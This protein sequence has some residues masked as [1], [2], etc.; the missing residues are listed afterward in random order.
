MSIASEISRIKQNIAS[1][2]AACREKAADL[3]QTQNSA[4]LASTIDSIAVGVPVESLSYSQINEQVT[5]FL[6]SVTYDPTDY[7]VSHIAEYVIDHDGHRPAGATITAPVPG[8]LTVYDGNGS[9]SNT[10]SAGSITVKNITPGNTGIYVLRDQNDEIAATGLLKPTGQLRMVDGGTTTFNIRDI[11]GWACDG[12]ALKHGLLFRGCELNGEN[13]VSINEEQRKLFVDFLG[14]R[15]EVDLRGDSETDGNDDIP[16][17]NDDI[18]SSALGPEVD[19]ARYPIIQ[20]G[21]TTD[22]QRELYKNAL[23]RMI[24]SI[25]AG[26][27]CY[28]HCMQG[29]DR[30]GT[31]IALIEGLCGVSQR[32][33][34]KD[35]ELT[36]LYGYS[37]CL[38]ERTNPD[39]VR[40]INAISAM[41][42]NLF[43]DKVVSYV[44][45]LGVSIQSINAL[46]NALINGSPAQ[47]TSPFSDAGVTKSLADISIDNP[48]AS[49]PMYQPYVLNMEPVGSRVISD[50][51]VT[52]G[53]VDITQSVFSGTKTLLRRNITKTLSDCSID[54]HKSVI[55]D[56]ECYAATITA[57]S[58]YTMNGATVNITMGGINVSNYYSDGK[59][60]IPRVTG[61][62]VIT[63]TAVS[64][65][66]PTNWIKESVTEIG[67]STIYNGVGYKSETRYKSGM[68]E[69]GSTG[70]FT[71]GYIKLEPGDVVRLYGGIFSATVG[72]GQT[73]P[74]NL[75]TAIY[76]ASGTKLLQFTIQTIV[77]DASAADSSI[78]LIKPLTYDPATMAMTAF[79]WSGQTDAW[80]KFTL[81]GA[82]VDGTT[83]ITINEEI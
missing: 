42:G 22:I 40:F 77:N 41:E 28:V 48:A 18:T 15:D 30:T 29:A 2:Y 38:R 56:G 83:A 45:T 20:Y 71:T 44:L 70:S 50:V 16:G 5:S 4:N 7:T 47:L 36:S 69:E 23:N 19:Y 31:I 60:I 43:R 52:M 10:V 80:V 33:I 51:V 76:N 79:T 24:D 12:G 17:T 27:P 8:V 67:G 57:H 72:G 53:N 74:A 1:A 78:A 62:I 61:N 13:G 59:I 34:D 46:R 82:F 65:A 35:Y 73:A 55:T 37:F 21:A 54:N 39:W 63:A 68:G 64:Q 58:G 81:T 3:P 49:T 32:D 11:G 14:I 25:V 26:R 75:N 9:M 6:S 66:P